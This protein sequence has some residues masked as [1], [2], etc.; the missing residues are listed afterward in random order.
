MKAVW[1]SQM[2]EQTVDASHALE[3]EDWASRLRESAEQLEHLHGGG[4]EREPDARNV[5]RELEGAG[6]RDVA[7]ISLCP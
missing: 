4:G 7:G 5:G 3:R 6:V 1:R 2:A